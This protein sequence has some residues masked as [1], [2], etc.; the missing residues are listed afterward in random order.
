MG[1]A[2]N[3]RAGSLVLNPRQRACRV[4]PAENND[5]LAQYSGQRFVRQPIL[6]AAGFQ[7]SLAASGDSRVTRRAPEKRLQA[8][9]PAPH[10]KR[11][12]TA[13]CIMRGVLTMAL[14]VPADP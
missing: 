3:P 5:A 8:K 9:L 13:S 1:R 4:E 7:P 2:G 11:N 6:V 10:Q 14:T 12:F